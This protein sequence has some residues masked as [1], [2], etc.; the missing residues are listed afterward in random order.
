MGPPWASGAEGH[1]EG[2][3]GSPEAASRTASD[4]LALSVA[5]R[6]LPVAAP[7]SVPELSPPSDFVTSTEARSGKGSKVRDPVTGKYVFHTFRQQLQQQ[8]QHS[9][10]EY[11]QLSVLDVM[12]ISARGERRRWKRLRE[13]ADEQGAAQPQQRIGEEFLPSLS[14]TQY[15]LGVRPVA[16]F[17]CDYASRGCLLRSLF[18]AC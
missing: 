14:V 4:H 17:K 8:L 15:V 1:T 2:T 10:S 13:D 18:Q 11:G 9:P 5:T 16:A 6:G 12:E 3:Q 7:P